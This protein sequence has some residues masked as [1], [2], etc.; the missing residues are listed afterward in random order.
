M[1]HR[2]LDGKASRDLPLDMDLCEAAFASTGAG[3]LGVQ[4]FPERVCERIFQ[5]AL[6]EPRTGGGFR[7]AGAGLVDLFLGRW[8]DQQID[9]KALDCKAVLKHASVLQGRDVFVF[10]LGQPQGMRCI[11]PLLDDRCGREPK[12]DQ[13]EALDDGLPTGRAREALVEQMKAGYEATHWKMCTRKSMRSF[14][15]TIGS[16]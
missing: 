7:L 10:L 13:I 12:S 2:R 8:L 15:E 5:S 9:P 14:A 4:N 6:F 1:V 3:G 11:M 16:L